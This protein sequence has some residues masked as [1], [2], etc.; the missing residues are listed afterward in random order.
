MIELNPE[1]PGVDAGPDLQGSRGAD[2]EPGVSERRW[3]TDRDVC[4]TYARATSL[5]FGLKN[6]GVSA[7]DRVVIF[8]PNSLTVVHVWMAINLLGAVD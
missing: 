5:A 7:G 1:M 3:K 6:L 2:A 8:A 4:E